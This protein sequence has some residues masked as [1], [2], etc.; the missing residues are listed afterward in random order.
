MVFQKLL[1]MTITLHVFFKFLD[2]WLITF[3]IP[4]SNLIFVA[5]LKLTRILIAIN[6]FTIYA[7]VYIYANVPNTYNNASHLIKTQFQSSIKI[8]FLL[9]RGLLLAGIWVRPEKTSKE[10][11]VPHPVPFQYQKGKIPL[12]HFVIFVQVGLC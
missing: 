3:H 2:E 9:W 4:S 5:F 8:R 10:T 6:L 7:D 1:I 12:A 11:L